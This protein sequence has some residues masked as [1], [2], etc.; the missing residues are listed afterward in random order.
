M[1]SSYLLGTFAGAGRVWRRVGPPPKRRHLL[2]DEDSQQGKRPLSIE[3]GHGLEPAL[4]AGSLLLEAKRALF[5]TEAFS[6]YLLS[7]HAIGTQPTPLTQVIRP[8][9]L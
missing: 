9:P 1:P 6:R 3:A 5:T 2:L 8:S 7:P 4:A